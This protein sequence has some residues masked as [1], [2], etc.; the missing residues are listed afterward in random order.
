MKDGC[1][2]GLL[3]GKHFK[4]GV[5]EGPRPM[6]NGDKAIII[7]ALVMFALFVGAMVVGMFY[8]SKNDV[9]RLCAMPDSAF[10]RVD[11]AVSL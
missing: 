2:H 3:Y 10:V 6:A 1:I 9:N 7:F 8:K 11:K 4:R 5:V